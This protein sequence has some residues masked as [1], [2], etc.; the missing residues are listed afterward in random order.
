MATFQEVAEFLASNHDELVL[1]LSTNERPRFESALSKLKRDWPTLPDDDA[2]LDI[3]LREMQKYPAVWQELVR[4]DLIPNNL[5]STPLPVIPPTTSVAER[6]A[7]DT[8]AR[9]P[10]KRT[11]PHTG[12]PANEHTT[13]KGPDDGHTA[14][15]DSKQQLSQNVAD[16][17]AIGKEL[18][19]G[20][21]GIIIILVTL[22]MV[23]ATIFT[24]SNV[25]THAAVKDALLFMNGLVGV[26]LGYYFG[27]VPGDT[28]ANQAENQSRTA[29]RERDRVV[30]EVRTVL[31]AGNRSARE[32]GSDEVSLTREQVEGL[33]RVLRQYDE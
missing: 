28:R 26:V 29:L 32:R 10:Q 24:V 22:T 27:R 7:E 25:E 9:E 13:D 4:A 5:L 20:I 8:P 2:K 15:K 30:T 16:R 14:T 33:Q 12:T 17:I 3:T 18:I 21:M 1:D 23:V 6:D 11:R 19:T 31:D